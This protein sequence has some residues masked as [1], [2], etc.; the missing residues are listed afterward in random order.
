MDLL[1]VQQLAIAVALSSLIGLERE[2]TYQ[3]GSYTNF[4][5][6]RTFA[7]IGLLGVVGYR[8]VEVSPFLFAALSAGLFALIVA[9][10]VMTTRSP[11]SA[12][13]TSEVAA[14]N[15]YLVGVLCGMQEFLLATAV[16]VTVLMILHFKDPL[17]KWAKRIKSA[18]LISTIQFILITF[19]VLPLLPNVAYGPYGFF[20]PFHVWLMVVFVSG[21]F[22]A[23]YI[24]IKTFGQKK[25]IAVTG[26][27]AGFISTT[28][29]AFG[30]AEE[31]KKNT[32]VILPYV[33][34]IVIASS[35]TFFR[36]LIE[37]FI[38]NRELADYIILPML[39]MGLVGGAISVV[40]YRKM[41]KNT[42][43]NSNL[44]KVKSP[45]RL[46]PAVKFGLLFAGILFIMKAA[47]A[48]IGTEAVYLLSLVLGGMDI[49]SITVTLANLANVDISYVVAS[50]ALTI[51]LISNVVAKVLIFAFFGSRRVALQLLYV[52]APVVA[53]GL[54][55]LMFIG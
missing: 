28:A 33:I 54:V 46:A 1:I 41:D 44:S 31:S 6:I 47:S 20:N 7:L 39:V 13:S 48:E 40:V 27:L 52:F 23:S 19:V 45:F 16:A 50:T 43:V 9:A 10:Y 8:L 53:A 30:F 22:F 15:A 21:I 34:G 17:H 18:E 5:G 55:T 42:V 36:V 35:A 49:D 25:G 14:F 3:T 24:A 32:K 11:K 12:G 51:A 4:G 26:L 38:L 37:V 2:H 29:L